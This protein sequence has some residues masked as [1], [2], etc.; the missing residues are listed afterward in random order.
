MAKRGLLSERINSEE[1]M[2]MSWSS[3]LLLLIVA[4]FKLNQAWH[5]FLDL[6]RNNHEI[7]NV[8]NILVNKYLE[9]AIS[10]KLTTYAYKQGNPLRSLLE[11]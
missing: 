5:L 1:A 3:D 2:L 7:L 10:R 6:K 4:F 11:V 8:A 9:D